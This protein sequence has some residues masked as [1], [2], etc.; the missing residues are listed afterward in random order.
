MGIYR[1]MWSH[2]EHS[3]AKIATYLSKNK[4]RGRCGNQANSS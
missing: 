1:F 3:I 4:R 2:Y